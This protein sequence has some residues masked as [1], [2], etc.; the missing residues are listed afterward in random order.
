[1]RRRDVDAAFYR[2][3]ADNRQSQGLTPIVD[4]N[5]I[6]CIVLLAVNKLGKA[7]IFRHSYSGFHRLTLGFSRVQKAFITFAVIV[8]LF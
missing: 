8:R 2:L 7:F 6:P 4:V 3:F 5:L 1:M